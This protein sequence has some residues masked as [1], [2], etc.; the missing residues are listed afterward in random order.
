MSI[1][2]LGELFS[3]PNR[4]ARTNRV[5]SYAN[6]FA[7]NGSPC[8]I[9][10]LSNEYGKEFAFPFE[11]IACYYP[12]DTQQRNPSFLLRNFKKA[13]KY[14]RL[15]RLMVELNRTSSPDALIVYSESLFI[16]I[17]VWV[18]SLGTGAK[19]LIEQSE[20]PY[21]HARSN[22]IALLMT[23][24]K[25]RILTYLVDR[26]ICVNRSVADFYRSQGV[27]AG[28]LLIV[29]ITVDLSRFNISPKSSVG[30]E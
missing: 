14:W 7:E 25:V 10:C 4:D 28:R 9:I 17:V 13:N 23:F 29:P 22:P 16:A 21:R 18:M 6:G 26:I 3:I 27:A 1:V 11:G 12:F 30:Y 8:T 15:W 5:M 2:V 24:I 19:V 20:D